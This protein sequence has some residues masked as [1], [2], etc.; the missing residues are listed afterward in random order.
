[1][2]A[3]DD[4]ESPNHLSA[5]KYSAL[6]CQANI[7]REPLAIRHSLSQIFCWLSK[8]CGVIELHKFVLAAIKATSTAGHL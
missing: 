5:Y 3:E 1:M 8:P 4:W 7:I 2:Y 6:Y